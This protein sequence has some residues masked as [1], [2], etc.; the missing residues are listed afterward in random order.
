MTGFFAGCQ[1][2]KE[3]QLE[4]EFSADPDKVET[5]V[6][7]TAVSVNPDSDTARSNASIPQVVLELNYTG[8]VRDMTKEGCGFMIE[9]DYGNGELVLLEPQGLE[10]EYQVEGK[11]IE[12]SYSDSRRASKCTSVSSKSIIITNIIE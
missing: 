8:T 6:I 10:P 9:L 7:D 4:E 11:K 3:V 5:V 1:N 12:F 2:H